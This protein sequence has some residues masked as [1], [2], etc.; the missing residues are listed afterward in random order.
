MTPCIAI[1]D[2]NTLSAIALKGIVQD[3]FDL[4]EVLTYRNI[5][6]F[7]GDC[8][9]FFVNYFV[10]ASV[11]LKSAEEFELLKDKTIVTNEGPG[12]PFIDAGFGVIDTSL[13]EKE[14]IARILQ[15]QRSGGHPLRMRKVRGEEELSSRERDVLALLA[16]GYINKEIADRLNISLST[17]IFHRNNICE[18]LGTRSLGRL[19]IFAVLSNIVNI[20]E[21]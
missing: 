7:L 1:I 18:K 2:P 17:V 10:S 9:H 5:E 15:L 12:Q 6:E 16:R 13:P 14:L 8:D 20:N 19:T 4:A 3:L 11:M 21:I